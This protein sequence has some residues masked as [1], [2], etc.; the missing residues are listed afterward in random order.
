MTV[1]IIPIA[2]GR[3]REPLSI[4]LIS[5]DLFKQKLEYLHYNPVKAGLCQN[6]EDYYYSSARFYHDGLDSFK[7]LTHFT[8]N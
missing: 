2:I 8:C 5:I 4:E 7:M 1:N 6:P 3:K